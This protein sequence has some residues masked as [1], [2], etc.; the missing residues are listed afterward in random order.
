MGRKGDG[1][2]RRWGGPRWGGGRRGGGEMG[3]GDGGGELHVR[4]QKNER[5]ERQVRERVGEKKRV[6]ERKW[7]R[8]VEWRG[9]RRRGRG[10]VIEKVDSVRTLHKVI[11]L[12]CGIAL[13]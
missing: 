13:P 11:K 4:K 1:E 12:E 8:E 3:R 5:K 10:R 9:K 2:E 7:W 6:G